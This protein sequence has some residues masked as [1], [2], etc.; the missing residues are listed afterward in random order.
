MNVV[1]ANLP[2]GNRFLVDP[3]VG[4]RFVNQASDSRGAHGR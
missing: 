1:A 3:F 4:V 2:S